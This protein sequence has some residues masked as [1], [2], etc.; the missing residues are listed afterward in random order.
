MPPLVK[1][2]FG[3]AC[4]KAVVNTKFLHG[5]ID[6]VQSTAQQ[7]G[8]GTLSTDAQF[9]GCQYIFEEAEIMA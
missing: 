2:P 3:A 5:T 6:L 8:E 4:A 1:M 9:I 7:R